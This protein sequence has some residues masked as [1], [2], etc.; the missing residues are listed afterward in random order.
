MSCEPARLESNNTSRNKSRISGKRVSRKPRLMR[1]PPS[2]HR[3]VGWPSSLLLSRARL[4]LFRSPKLIETEATKQRECM[5]RKTKRRAAQAALPVGISWYKESPT[6]EEV[7]C[8]GEE[9]E[10]KASEPDFHYSRSLSQGS[11][12][13]ASCFFWF[14]RCYWRRFAFARTG[15]LT[16]SGDTERTVQ[17][18][19]KWADGRTAGTRRDGMRRA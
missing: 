19:T 7:V 13:W 18:V 10:E 2:A 3:L 8:G 12:V 17:R 14:L 11:L 6:G 16:M 15:A 1:H 5:R 9:G 4:A